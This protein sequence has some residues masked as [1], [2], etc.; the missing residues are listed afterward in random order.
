[1]A[2]KVKSK[3]RRMTLGMNRAPIAVVVVLDRNIVAEMVCQEMWEYAHCGENSQFCSGGRQ[4]EIYGIVRVA[5]ANLPRDDVISKPEPHVVTL[6]DNV[7][8]TAASN[9]RPN[10]IRILA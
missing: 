6:P 4:R 7:I 3:L 8:V 10:L 2:K 1:M 5:G 9:D